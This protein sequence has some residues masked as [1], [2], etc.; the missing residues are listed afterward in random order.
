MAA[1]LASALALVLA[2]LLFALAARRVVRRVTVFEHQRAV[3][4]RRGKLARVLEPGVHWLTGFDVATQV[5]DVRPHVFVVP[6]QEVLT[7]DGVGLKVSLA[8]EVAIVDPGAAAL[9]SQ[10]AELALHAEAQLRLRAAVGAV[11]A[12]E[13]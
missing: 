5:V 10:N 9:T 7:R 11:S 4:Y 2:L 1:S 8:G 6:G 13:F 12:E 3:L